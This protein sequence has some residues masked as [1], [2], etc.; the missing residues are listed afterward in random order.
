MDEL[1]TPVSTTYLKPRK[2][3]ESLLTEVKSRPQHGNSQIQRPQAINSSEDA[4]D[5]LKS[6]PDYDTLIVTLSFLTSNKSASDGF[7]LGAPS[8]K[9]AAIIHQ[10]VVEIAPNYWTL[11]LEG[12]AREDPHAHDSKPQDAELF[13]RCLR[14]VT[15]LNAI[16]TQIRALLHDSRLGGGDIKRNDTELNL[17]IFLDLLG[18]LLSGNK[19]VR[20]MWQYSTNELV[21]SALKKAQSQKLCSLLTNGQ[22]TSMAAEALAVNNSSQPWNETLWIADGVEYSKWLARNITTWAIHASQSNELDACSDLFQRSL[23]LNY[24]GKSVQSYIPS[25]RSPSIPR[26]SHQGHH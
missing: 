13:L 10:L 25:C 1:F 26:G 4:L 8:P 2:E 23:S 6:Q 12:T 19:T 11:L 3:P 14:S 17:G 9:S 7:R 20:D 16:I 24:T 21:N 18:V 22:I 15:G 5:A